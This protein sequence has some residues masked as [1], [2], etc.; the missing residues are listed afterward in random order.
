MS[1]YRDCE[2]FSCESDDDKYSISAKDIFSGAFP[3]GGDKR[4]L[5][6]VGAEDMASYRLENAG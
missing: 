1:F 2:Y 5:K 3:T 6:E 4:W